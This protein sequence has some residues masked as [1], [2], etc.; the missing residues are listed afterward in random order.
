MAIHINTAEFKLQW[1]FGYF[2]D[3]FNDVLKNYNGI[4]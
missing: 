1:I 2:N 4:F 3:H